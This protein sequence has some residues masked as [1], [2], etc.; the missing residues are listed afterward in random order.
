MVE[1]HYQIMLG[2]LYGY[3][4]EALRSST[5]DYITTEQI[6]TIEHQGMLLESLTSSNRQ[7]S[8]DFYNCKRLEARLKKDLDAYRAFCL[9]VLKTVKRSGIPSSKE[10]ASTLNISESVATDIIERVSVNK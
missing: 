8:K 10:L 1:G 5:G 3:V 2:S 9:E 4:M 7:L 6:R